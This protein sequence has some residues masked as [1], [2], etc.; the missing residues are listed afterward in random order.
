MK[1]TARKAEEVDA[2]A[3]CRLVRSSISI[4][5]TADHKNDA[6]TLAKWLENKTEANFIRWINS[7][8][9]RAFVAELNGNVVGFA[10]LNLSGVIALLY[11]DPDFRFNGVSKTML[12]AIEAEANE[13]G[14]NEL[15][16]DSSSTALRFYSGAGYAKSSEAFKGF[17]VTVCHPMVKTLSN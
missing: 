10:L 2:V 17:G 9:H 12:S 3:A 7:I 6:D 8:Q 13:L 16:L 1:V 5:C 11:V 4:L 15:S 14:I